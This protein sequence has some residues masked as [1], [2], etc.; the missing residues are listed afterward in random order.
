MRIGALVTNQ[1]RQ[2]FKYRHW[3]CCTPLVF[4]NIKKEIGDDP[5][6][7]DGWDELKEEDQDK[8]AEAFQDDEVDRDE[9]PAE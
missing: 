5:V 7:L 4:K 8:F 6:D 1:D 3:Y 2:W 9:V